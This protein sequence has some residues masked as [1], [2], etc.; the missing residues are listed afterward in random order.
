MS[1]LRKRRKAPRQRPII[2]H[3]KNAGLYVSASEGSLGKYLWKDI[4]R[5]SLLPLLEDMPVE[6]REPAV[7]RLIFG[8]LLTQADSTMINNDIAPEPGVTC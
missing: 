7:Q 1:R 3:W 5:S 6:S 8:A 4:K 2:K